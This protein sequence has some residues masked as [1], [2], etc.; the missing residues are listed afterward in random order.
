M[1]ESSPRHPAPAG[2]LSQI[3]ALAEPKKIARVINSKQIRGRGKQAV[4]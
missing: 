2:K 3:T 1:F 4:A